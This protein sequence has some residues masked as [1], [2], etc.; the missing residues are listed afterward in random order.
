MG[1]QPLWNFASK[2]GKKNFRNHPMNEKRQY[3][4]HNCH[5]KVRFSYYEGDPDKIN[6]QTAVPKKGN[7]LILDISRGGLFVATDERISVN[8]PL[9]VEFKTKTQLF[10]LLGSV[11]RTGL[12]KNNPSEVVQKYSK[13]KIKEDS[14]LAVQFTQP[15]DFLDEDDIQKL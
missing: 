1:M 7:G 12:L 14:Y 6:L 13:M 11:V 15:L 9:E 4:R 8:M 10:S 2:P 3:P 5:M